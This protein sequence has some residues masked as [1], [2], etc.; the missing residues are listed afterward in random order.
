MAVESA[1]QIGSLALLSAIAIVLIYISAFRGPGNVESMKN[2]STIAAGG[3]G[4]I[5]VAFA[6]I[7]LADNIHMARWL[8]VLSAIGAVLSGLCYFFL[9][10]FGTEIALRVWYFLQL[11]ALAIGGLALFLFLVVAL[12]SVDDAPADGRQQ[13]PVGELEATPADELQETP[14]DQSQLTPVNE[15]QETPV[16]EGQKTPVETPTKGTSRYPLPLSRSRHQPLRTYTHSAKR[17]LVIR[18][19]D[20]AFRL[21]TEA[22]AMYRKIGMP[23]HIEMAEAMLGEV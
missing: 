5:L 22:I 15:H 23:K 13:T 2:V 7:G 6:G 20:K 17:G 4:G 10:G 8:L 14:V 3:A 12:P 18:E 11:V 9:Q 21:L 19:R 16:D 1:L